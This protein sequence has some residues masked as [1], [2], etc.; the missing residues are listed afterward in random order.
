MLNTLKVL[1]IEDDKNTRDALSYYLKKR[2]GKLII[3]GML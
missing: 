2:T 1:Y 3:A